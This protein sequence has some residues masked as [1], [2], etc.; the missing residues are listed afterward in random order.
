MQDKKSAVPGHS[1][2]K[3][4]LDIQF[5]LICRSLR[6]RMCIGQIADLS[7]ERYGYLILS[8]LYRGRGNG[9]A[10]AAGIVPEFVVRAVQFCPAASVL[11]VEY[12]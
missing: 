9:I 4:Y 7:I 12:D 3:M 5:K 10:I 8:S 2:V 11:F 6:L 1:T